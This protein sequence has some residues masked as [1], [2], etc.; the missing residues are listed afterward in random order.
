MQRMH[1]FMKSQNIWK[2]NMKAN[3]LSKQEKK[4]FKR[5]TSCVSRYL[6][7]KYFNLSY[8]KKRC[9]ELCP[10]LFSFLFLLRGEAVGVNKVTIVP[11][12]DTITVVEFNHPNLSQFVK[13]CY[14]VQAPFSMS[15]FTVSW[16]FRPFI[17]VRL[18]NGQV[19]NNKFQSR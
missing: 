12:F 6:L 16:P 2:L 13:V 10:L 14:L 17:R 15:G 8:W 19:K 7:W 11:F 5:K 1:S 9:R 3:F 4:S 18:L